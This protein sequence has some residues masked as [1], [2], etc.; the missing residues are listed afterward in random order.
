MVI[1]IPAGLAQFS[2]GQLGIWQ[3][4]E[5][6]LKRMNF[7]RAKGIAVLRSADDSTLRIPGQ[8]GNAV[9]RLIREK[10]LMN[11]GASSVLNSEWAAIV[12]TELAQR[13][14]AKRIR[15]G[16]VEVSVSNSAVL[17]ELRGFMHQQ[18][19][20]ELQK[21]LPESGIRGIRYRRE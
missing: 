1:P 17:E 14:T 16:V 19:L 10:G 6:H 20:E 3:F 2:R 7:S 4:R 15:N 5:R 18:V 9:L 13:S 21:R 11:R 12:G 8:V